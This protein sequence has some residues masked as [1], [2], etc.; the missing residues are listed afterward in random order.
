MAPPLREAFYQ[1]LSS[2]DLSHAGLA[3][4]VR[5][6]GRPLAAEMRSNDLGGPAGRTVISFACYC[7]VDT[8]S[9]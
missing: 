7:R 8:G 3:N 9:H 4:K 5:G 2:G 1:L 6:R